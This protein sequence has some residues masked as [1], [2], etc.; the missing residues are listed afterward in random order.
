[1]VNFTLGVKTVEWPNFA[2]DPETMG[3]TVDG[4]AENFELT[5]DGQ[6]IYKS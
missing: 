6:L 5:E 1:M 4:M 3:L 2:I